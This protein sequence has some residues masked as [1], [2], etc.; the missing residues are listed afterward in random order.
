MNNILT[1]QLT[2]LRTIT[3]L[4]ALV[5]TRIFPGKLPA[6]T[7]TTPTPMPCLTYQ[8]V[9]EPVVTTHDNQQLFTAR[10]QFDAWGGSYGS[11][12]AVADALYASVQGY[13]GFMGA[14]PVGSVFRQLKRDDSDPDISLYRVIQ[15]FV[16]SYG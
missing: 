15:D 1:A 14:V 9:D 16:F 3:A 11:A 2:Y 7:S 10:I 12:H 8:M 4:T 5:S 13:K 6:G